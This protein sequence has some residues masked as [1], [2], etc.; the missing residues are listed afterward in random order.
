[1]AFM[2]DRSHSDEVVKYVK[3]DGKADEPIKSICPNCLKEDDDGIFCSVCGGKL[4]IMKNSKVINKSKTLDHPSLKKI[5]KTVP[6]SI[7]PPE[8]IKSS[9]P[10][11]E[12]INLLGVFLGVLFLV[13]SFIV[14]YYASLSFLISS[15]D[16][17]A[18]F[19]FAFNV[20]SILILILGTFSGILASYIGKFRD[21]VDGLLN[22]FVV[23]F[24]SMIIL[25]VYLS[26]FFEVIGG[27]LVFIIGIPIIG[28][29]TT[30]G[31][32]IGVFLRLKNVIS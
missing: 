13:T 15:F 1:M 4:L 19:E 20:F 29:L 12:R 10:F 11:F 8:N 18:D 28:A 17:F 2:L 3:E 26:L 14:S 7:N 30:I 5:P 16:S 23:G 6:R 9:E 25:G 22:G 27:I 21:Y 31:G 32:L 24:I